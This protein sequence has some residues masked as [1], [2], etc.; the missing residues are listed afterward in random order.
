MLI[1]IILKTIARGNTIKKSGA[2]YGRSS[3]GIFIRSTNAVT[4][5]RNIAEN[6]MRNI[7]ALARISIAFEGPNVAMRRTHNMPPRM[8]DHA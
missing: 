6:S 4:P 3:A 8:R 2:L 7:P 5:A 1:R